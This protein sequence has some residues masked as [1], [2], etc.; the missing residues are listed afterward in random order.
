MLV[1]IHAGR[2]TS[3]LP[4]RLLV[5]R[6]IETVDLISSPN[7]SCSLAESLIPVAIL[8]LMPVP[9]DSLIF[10]IANNRRALWHDKVP[11]L[12]RVL[13]HILTRN[14]PRSTGRSLIVPHA[15]L[16]ILIILRRIWV[17]VLAVADRHIE[18]E[19]RVRVAV[20]AAVGVL[21][22]MKFG[23]GG[24][25]G[26]ELVRRNAQLQVLDILV[27]DVVRVGEVEL[28][29]DGVADLRV[30]R[31]GLVGDLR[32]FIRRRRP[33]GEVSAVGY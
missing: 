13:M 1:V 5:I 10:L 22:G 32:A 18:L 31:D 17:E 21:V 28:E 8:S 3:L 33:E 4:L 19:A 30:D 6:A 7:S 20:H 11:I 27:S 9:I 12:I 24:V 2:S 23:V 16:L 14:P 15:T 29:Q 25:G 26:D